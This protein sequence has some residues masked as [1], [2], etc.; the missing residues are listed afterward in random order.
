MNTCRVVVQ[1]YGGTTTGN[2]ALRSSI[3]ERIRAA[4][5]SGFQVVAVVSAMG[6]IGDP[7]ATETLLSTLKGL[8]R[9]AC[10]RECDLLMSCGELISAVI[11]ATELRSIG[12]SCIARAGF[13]A[14][15]ITN[16]E[17]GNAR[18]LRI[19]PEQLRAD[20]EL[21]NTVV[22]A[23]FQGVSESGHITT[24][25][26]GGSDTS[27][28]AIGAAL[29][30]ELVEIYTDTDGV[31]SADPQVVDNAR[32][33]ESMNSEDIRQMAWQ[34]AKVLHPRAVELAIRHKVKTVIGHV[35]RS[36]NTTILTDSFECEAMITGIACGPLVD[37]ISVQFEA[38]DSHSNAT[39][40]FEAVA[41]A[42]VSMDMFT[43]TERL[44][45]FTTPVT[46]RDVVLTTLKSLTFPVSIRENCRKISIVGA[47]MHG[48]RGVMARFARCLLNAGIQLFQ[49]VDSH[50]TISGLIRTEDATRSQIILHAEFIDSNG[51]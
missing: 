33:L 26:R 15:I 14:G 39:E 16:S 9:Y 44:V 21:F 22:I 42:G 1:K 45:R 6:R 30:A 13:E 7:Y 36:V 38:S 25:G 27:A 43:L 5:A 23:G 11:I 51:N 47:G 19:E 24:L 4:R 50:A 3:F 40:V 48:M 29:N 46:L 31:F 32:F 2:P 28:I 49:T 12:V 17:Y 34:G 37:Q 10:R 35:A 20:L 41:A 8:E 18:I